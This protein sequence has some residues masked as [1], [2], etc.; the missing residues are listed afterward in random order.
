MSYGDF[1]YRKAE[2]IARNEIL[3]FL[4]VIL[5]T[6][7]LMGGLLVTIIAAEQ[8]KWFL[9][10]YQLPSYPSAFLGLI[11]TLTGFLLVSV[12][13]I[14]VI[15][16]DRRKSWCMNQMEESRPDK[17]GVVTELKLE[18]IRRILEEHARSG[19]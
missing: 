8:P 19:K 18:R 1:L 4:T 6:V 17:K 14:M 10:P 2:D 13:F 11:L 16:Y 5:G 3:S 7:I 15:Y 9:L 12:G